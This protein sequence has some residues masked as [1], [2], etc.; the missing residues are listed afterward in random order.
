M[1]PEKGGPRNNKWAE[2]VRYD[3]T[4]TV[5]SSSLTPDLCVQFFENGLIKGLGLVLRLLLLPLQV[6]GKAL[7]RFRDAVP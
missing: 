5:M 7:L 4:F 3:S 6:V 1:K 2:E